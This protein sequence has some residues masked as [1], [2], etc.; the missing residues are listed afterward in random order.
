MSSFLTGAVDDRRVL[1][2]D[3]H[4]LGV[5]E[6]VEGD[7]LELDAKVFRD[8]LTTRERRDVL[9][10][11]LAA[12]AEARRLNRRHLEAAAELVDDEGG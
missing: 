4:P 3:P 12:I 1:L 7:V 5:A 6:H 8:D 10:H 9:E 2:L 11:R